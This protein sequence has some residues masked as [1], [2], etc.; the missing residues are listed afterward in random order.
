MQDGF[1]GVSWRCVVPN[2]NISRS[3][4]VLGVARHLDESIQ[5]ASM[6]RSIRVNFCVELV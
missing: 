2:I 3:N 6:L 1:S 4:K 5:A